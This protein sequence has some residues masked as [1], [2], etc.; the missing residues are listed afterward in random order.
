MIY[1]FTTWISRL[2]LTSSLQSAINDSGGKLITAQLRPRPLL[3]RR[4]SGSI[5]GICCGITGK[6]WTFEFEKM[7]VLHWIYPF[8]Q[9]AIYRDLLAKM[10]ESWVLTIACWVVL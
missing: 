7:C 9:D 4:S 1:I 10:E 3:E 8:T 2:R 6:G 5:A